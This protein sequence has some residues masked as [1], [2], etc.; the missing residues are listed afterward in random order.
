MLP[1]RLSL[2]FA[3]IYLVV[4]VAYVS[5]SRAYYGAVA[6]RISK[7]PDGFPPFTASRAAAAIM[8]YAALTIAWLA[9]VPLATRAWAPTLA[10]CPTMAALLAGFLL[11]FAIYGVFNGTL[12]V[13]FA[14]YDASVV[15]RDMLWGLTWMT[16]LSGAYGLTIR[17]REGRILAA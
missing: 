14:D 4:D 11:A 6:G 12:Y 10:G 8:S 17:V 9:F 5:A 13:M 7:S 16:L 3:A 1:T 15:R 2:L